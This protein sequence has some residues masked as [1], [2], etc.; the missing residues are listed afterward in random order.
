MFFV[1]F[2]VEVSLLI[3]LVTLWLAASASSCFA[4]FSFYPRADKH[5]LRRKHL[6]YLPL[7]PLVGSTRRSLTSLSSSSSSRSKTASVCLKAVP[8]TLG[9]VPKYYYYYVLLY[10]A[11]QSPKS[12]MEHVEEV[13]QSYD[14]ES[15][16]TLQE[17]L[18]IGPF[19]SCPAENPDICR[20]QVWTLPRNNRAVLT[21]WPMCNKWNRLHPETIFWRRNFYAFFRF[22]PV[23]EKLEQKYQNL[24]ILKLS[25]RTTRAV[26]AMETMASRCNR[27][28]CIN[29]LA[30]FCVVSSNAYKWIIAATHH[31]RSDSKL[32]CVL[33]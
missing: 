29:I 27:Y 20:K 1:F 11:S 6:K 26:Q 24:F 30:G 4:A 2:F 16:K 12:R 22:L 3:Q 9:S 18:A 19:R 13:G 5:C 25:W 14:P 23:D 32:K 15:V 33:T 7:W 10:Y 28:T 21:L 8:N 17:W 31:C